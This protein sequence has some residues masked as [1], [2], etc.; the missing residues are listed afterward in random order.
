VSRPALAASRAVDILNFMAARPSESFSLSELVEHLDVNFASCHAI[1]SVLTQEGFLERHPKHRTYSLGTA[2]VAIGHAALESHPAI[3]IARDEARDLA[4]QL[5]LEVLLT[6]RTGGDLIALAR[7]GR[8]VAPNAALPVG[9]RMP[10][11][12]PLGAPF[13]AWASDAEVRKWLGDAPVAG[14]P[15]SYLDLLAIVRE[16]GYAVTLR[17]P[18]QSELGETIAHLSD[19]PHATGLRHRV[20]SLIGELGVDV[21]HLTALHP[22]QA[23]DVS[24]LSAPIFNVHGHAAFTLSLLGFRDRLTAQEI[25]EHA[26]RLVACCLVTTRKSKGRVP[27]AAGTLQHRG[28]RS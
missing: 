24:I 4:Q 17:S 14:D 20:T 19:S 1:L 22:A 7:A 23:Y 27:Q 11:I 16:R 12:P 5:D 25:Q 21:Y 10:M 13:M 6:A 8:Y 26:E 2:L 28:G 9:Q 18:V 3:D 15:K